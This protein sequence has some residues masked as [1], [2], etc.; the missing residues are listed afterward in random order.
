MHGPAL[1]RLR[2]RGRAAV[3]RSI[4][5]PA[6][7]VEAVGDTPATRRRRYV[8]ARRAGGQAVRPHRLARVAGAHG[9]VVMDCG[10][11]PRVRRA[12]A[13]KRKATRWRPRRASSGCK[14]GKQAS[15]CQ[16]R[17]SAGPS[18][19]TSTSPKPPTNAWRSPAVTLAECA[20]AQSASASPCSLGKRSR[21]PLV[22]PS[23]GTQNSRPKRA[24]T[25]WNDKWSSSQTSASR[26]SEPVLDAPL[27]PLQLLVRRL[28]RPP[29]SSKA[30]SVSAA[31]GPSSAPT[32]KSRNRSAEASS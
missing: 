9:A 17:Q 29:S 15:T 12:V 8:G 4:L 2:A 28:A 25:L 11:V 21:K 6:A 23:A 27:P 22:W 16:R 5:R 13:R 3:L 7:P 1:R 20:A 14:R 10:A 26:S 32:S 31:A 30:A 19:R 18:G 24:E